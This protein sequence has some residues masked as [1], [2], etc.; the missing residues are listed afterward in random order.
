MRVQYGVLLEKM[1]KTP[2]DQAFS[3]FG[4][5]WELTNWAIIIENVLVQTR[6]F[7]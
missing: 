7:E 2:I 3:Y 5:K 6:L 4:E 1:K